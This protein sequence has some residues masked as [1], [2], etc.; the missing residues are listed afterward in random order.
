MHHG[1][2]CWLV[3][4]ATCVGMAG[5]LTYVN[6]YKYVYKY[7]RIKHGIHCRP[8]QCTYRPITGY[9][10]VRIKHHIRM[11][12]YVRHTP[13]PMYV[14]L[15]CLVM[16]HACVGA[17][18]GAMGLTTMVFACACSCVMCT[19]VHAQVCLPA[20]YAYCIVFLV[21]QRSLRAPRAERQRPSAQCQFFFV[22]P[23]PLQLDRSKRRAC[24]AS[25][26]S[27]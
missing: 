26:A 17:C 8:H 27:C 18:A 11:Y 23:R 2:V 6:V 13:G 14:S 10:H 16:R 3:R 4:D 21:T 19:W 5:G 15:P 12:V 24:P 7:V 1:D 25:S 9:T 22:S 20:W